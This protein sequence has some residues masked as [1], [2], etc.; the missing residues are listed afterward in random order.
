MPSEDLHAAPT[1]RELGRR[2]R[3]KA[4][5]RASISAAALEL[6]LERGFDAVSIRDIAGRA[7]VA[8]A[9]I[10]AHFSGK[11]ALVFDDD[12]TIVSSLVAA[13]EQREEGVD[14]LTAMERWFL[15][16]SEAHLARRR[17]PGF[18]AF[19]RLV[20]TTPALQAYWRGMWRRYEPRVTAAIVASTGTDPQV[21]RLTTVLVI[22]G[23]LIA[24]ESPDPREPLELVFGVL[25]GGLPTA[26]T[27]DGP[28]SD[29]VRF[30]A[31]P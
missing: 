2:E 3:K 26:P 30:P 5:T 25:R 11:E 29:G 1:E 14:A 12:E 20:E 19:H 22:E 4:A 10:F 15:G 13:V 23:Y 24:S 17:D 18:A 31:S 27:A 28:E 16:G 21:A 9:T 7:D 6:F 8:V